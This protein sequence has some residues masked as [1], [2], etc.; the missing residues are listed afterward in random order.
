MTLFGLPQLAFR[1][2]SLVDPN[3]SQMS[4]EFN[5][6][7]E[8]V[9]DTGGI[10]GEM[11]IGTSRGWLQAKE[12]QVGDKVLMA[13]MVWQEVVTVAASKLWAGVK[14]CPRP[15]R[16]LYVPAWV[17]DNSE[18]MTLLAEQYL[19]FEDAGIADLF[20]VDAVYVKAAHLAGSF[21]IYYFSP[22]SPLDVIHLE[23]EDPEI[24]MVQG[25]AK[26]LCPHGIVQ[27]GKAVDLMAENMVAAA[28][29]P[30][31]PATCI[32]ALDAKQARHLLTSLYRQSHSHR[33]GL[34]VDVA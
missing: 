8:Y 22:D 24:V 6:P 17:L 3:T 9:S 30:L 1:K 19:L 15:A 4:E 7:T 31:A 12:I 2:S 34:T 14:E 26:V 13:D 27:R 18:P 21:G 10:V 11:L 16:P 20:G 28:A 29:D 25:G 32:P 5:A 33:V 23:F